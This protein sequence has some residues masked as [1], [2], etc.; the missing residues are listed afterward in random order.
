MQDRYTFILIILKIIIPHHHH[1]HHGHHQNLY[2]LFVVQ[3][4]SLHQHSQSI[5]HILYQHQYHHHLYHTYSHIR[6]LIYILNSA[7]IIILITPIFT[8]VHSYTLI[9]T[10]VIECSSP[11]LV[12][13]QSSSVHSKRTE[14]SS[15]GTTSSLCAIICRFLLNYAYYSATSSEKHIYICA[16][17]ENSV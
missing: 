16:L 17:A 10:N 8:F 9:S 12:V 7:N 6:S 4:S 3:Y 13:V 14:A 15:V 11:L 2:I 1:Y 5:T